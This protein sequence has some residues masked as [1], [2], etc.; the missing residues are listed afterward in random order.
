MYGVRKMLKYILTAACIIFALFGLSEFLHL[1]KLKFISGKK[2]AT[3]SVLLLSNNLPDRQIVYAGEQRVW[4][5]KAYA[6]H[7]IVVN[8]GLDETDDIACRTA[9]DKYGIDYCTAEDL[10]KV[11]NDYI[12]T[13]KTYGGAPNG[14]GNSGK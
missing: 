2:A 1:L 9:A 11:L 5:G 8:T 6:D 3:Y 7:I 10:S 13:V 12:G 14:G 4:L